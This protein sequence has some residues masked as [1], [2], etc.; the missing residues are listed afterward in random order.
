MSKDYDSSAIQVLKGLDPVQRRPGMYTDTANPNHITQEIVDNSV[1]EAMAGHCSVISVTLTKDGYVRVED[2][3]R[4][5]P[6]DIHPTEGKSGVE[7]IMETL[8]GGGKFGDGNY[9]FSGGLHG[10]GASVTN[11]L[12]EHLIVEIK[13]DGKR[14]RIEYRD[15]N[16]ASG[17]L[18]ALPGR[19]NKSDTG[20]SVSFKPNAKYFDSPKIAISPLIKLLRIKAILHAGLTIVFENENT[21]ET[22]TFLYETGLTDYMKEEAKDGDVVGDIFFASERTCKERQMNVNYACYFSEGSSRVQQAFV[23]LI[24]TAQGGTHVNALRQGIFEGIREYAEIHNLIPRNLKIS[25]DDIWKNTN[26]IISLKMKEPNFAG[27]TKERLSSRECAPFINGTVK[28]AMSLF[29]SEHSEAAEALLTLVLSNANARL[30]ANKKIERKQLGKVLAMPGKLTDCETDNREEGELFVVEGD[31]AGGSAKQARNKQTQAIMPLRGKILNCWEKDESEIM[32][33]EEIKNIA[34]A[35]GVDPNSSDLSGL[36]YGKICILADAD[37]D[38]LH[39]ATL[40]AALFVRHFPEVIRNGNVYVAMP[41]L[42]RIDVGKKVFYA[43]DD[44]EKEKTLAKIRSEKLRGEVNVQRFKGLG[45]MNPSQLKETTMDPMTRRLVKLQ[46]DNEGEAMETFDML[47]RKKRS[48]D[49]K[50]WLESDGDRLELE[51]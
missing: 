38:G 40:F 2:D 25:P 41:P 39:I 50:A 32:R 48:K 44:D 19:I 20:T 8:H 33:S 37:S 16:K 15:G 22:E 5:M 49:R 9:E 6:V 23:N 11:A 4:G 31:S 36:R 21:G 30:K 42:Y 18:Q 24:P 7:V 43:L 12:S 13:R 10:V 3:G 26:F 35:I 1:D 46:F 14:H 45:E 17:A 27:Q 28:D 34:T 29:L 47:L 51:V